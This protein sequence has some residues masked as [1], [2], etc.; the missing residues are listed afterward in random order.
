[1]VIWDKRKFGKCNFQWIPK[2]TGKYY[3]HLYHWGYW[4]I[5][6]GKQ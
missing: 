5:H 3:K 6:F 4:G 2:N 1:M